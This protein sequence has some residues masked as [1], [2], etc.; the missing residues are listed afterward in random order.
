MAGPNGSSRIA[1]TSRVGPS[2]ELLPTAV[3][4]VESAASRWL[5][6]RCVRPPR[7]GSSARPPLFG[8][9]VCL[10][11][12]SR[13][14]PK[15]PRV[16][17][18]HRCT[19]YRRCRTRYWIHEVSSSRSGVHGAHGA[20]SRLGAVSRRSP[21][22]PPWSR[23]NP[24]PPLPPCVQPL[25]RGSSACSLAGHRRAAGRR[26]PSLPINLGQISCPNGLFRDMVV[27]W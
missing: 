6:P 23:R 18:C 25:R 2:F 24:A 3:P 5:P 19:R 20:L 9:F 27:W 4:P 21:P 22:P 1:E 15:P 13:P 17:Q 14:P 10:L 8:Q 7:H 16:A 12:C 11:A 26:L